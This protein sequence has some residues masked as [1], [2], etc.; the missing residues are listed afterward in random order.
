M[1]TT[2]LRAAGLAL[3]L[4]LTLAWPALAAPG[5]SPT[6]APSIPATLA[7]PDYPETRRVA[8][9]DTLHG[10]RIED[11]YRWLEDDRSPETAAWVAA[12]NRVTDA[13]LAQLPFREALR[14]RLTQLTDFARATVPERRGDWLY[15]RHNTG[16]QNQN[17]IVRQ[18]VAG[19]PME[20]VLDPNTLSADGTTAVRQFSI[21]PAGRWAAYTVSIGGSDWQQIRVLDLR[22]GQTLPERIDWVKVSGLAWAGD[23]F[24]Y[25]RYPAPADGR[26][27]SAKNE[28]HQVAF[29]RIGTP[30][31]EDALVHDDPANPQRFHWLSTSEDGRWAV[32]SISDRG[33]GQRGNALWVKDL[34]KPEARFV[35]VVAEPGVSSFTFVDTLGTGADARLLVRTN[36]RAPNGRA[37]LIDPAAPDEA[38]W[39]TVVPERAQPIQQ[40]HA[41]GGRIFVLRLQDATTRVEVLRA[42]GTPEREVQLPGLGEAEGFDGRADDR[43][44]YYRYASFDRPPTIYRYE[45]ASGR[46]TPFLAPTVAGF[47]PADYTVRQVFVPSKDGTRVPMFLVHRRGLAA[48]RRHPVL[49]YGYGGFNVSLTP[50]FSAQRVALLEQGVVFAVANLRGGGEYGQ[51]WHHA[52]TRLRKQNTFDDFIACAEWLIDQKITE[53]AKLAI[54][55]GSNGGLLVGVA[56]NQRPDLFA[57]A[58]PQVGVMDMLR[59]HKFT[60]GWNWIPDYGTPDD[61]AEFK[62]LHGYSPLHNIREGVRYPAVMVTTADHDDRVVP[63]HSFKYAAMLQAK[64]ARANPALIRIETKSGHGASSTAKRIELAT[65]TYAFLLHTLGVGFRREAS[66]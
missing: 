64:A 63:A 26:V 52:G 14:T 62:V 25:S 20:T 51:A 2:T 13:W 5:A 40:V 21:D 29:H 15:Y 23:G 28:R 10:Q 58:L 47:D 44:V 56:I 42:D 32:L 24:F 38:R 31:A 34:S 3:L 27:L 55:G 66:R 12:Q 17:L 46:S 36:H 11:P 48:D 33:R 8:Q 6:Q 41:A 1:T 16:L 39:T 35:P 65:D 19:G 54:E 50:W 57:A 18:R 22:T 4:P 45:L 37:V 59:F 43:A 7:V 49:L 30:V 9:V 60:I 53:P 61:P